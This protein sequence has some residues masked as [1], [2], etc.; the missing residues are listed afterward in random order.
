M[1]STICFD[2]TSVSC[3]VSAEIND[4]NIEVIAEIN[5][6]NIELIAQT[7]YDYHLTFLNTIYYKS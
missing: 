1:S 2:C 4:V 6:V 3:P 5:D 7:Y